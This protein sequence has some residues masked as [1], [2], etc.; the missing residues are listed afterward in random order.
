MIPDI[1]TRQNEKLQQDSRVIHMA[2]KDIMDKIRMRIMQMKIPDYEDLSSKQI[3][4]MLSHS[5]PQEIEDKI[6][7][8]IEHVQEDLEKAS[9]LS[10]ISFQPGAI[11]LETI[12]RLQ[13]EDEFCQQIKSEPTSYYTTRKGILLRIKSED[14]CKILMPK[15][16]LPECLI[17]MTIR[18]EHTKNMSVHLPFTRVVKTISSKY[19]FPK[20]YERI[21]NHVHKCIPC[22]LMSYHTRPPHKLSLFSQGTE[23]RQLIGLDL[24]VELPPVNSFKHVLVCVDYATNYVQAYPI[25]SRKSQD[26]LSAFTLF[27]QA[28]GIPHSVRH[29]QELGFTGAQFAQY[30]SDNNIEQLETLPYKANSNGKVEVQVRNF[31]HMLQKT[32]L[33]SDT[34]HQWP[35]EVWKVTV[36]LNT[37]VSMAYD[38]TPEEL[39][40]KNIL[41]NKQT[42]IATIT[43]TEHNQ[44]NLTTSTEYQKRKQQQQ[45]DYANKRRRTNTFEIGDL[46]LRKIICKAADGTKHAL[47]TKYNG[48]YRIM[49]K[50]DTTCIIKPVAENFHGTTVV[51]PDHLKPF[52][53]METPKL[54]P[55][56]NKAVARTLNM[57]NF[58]TMILLFMSLS[59]TL[60]SP[61]EITKIDII[62]ELDMKTQHMRKPILNDSWKNEPQSQ[63]NSKRGTNQPPTPEI[64][65]M[66]NPAR[67]EVHREDYRYDSDLI[68]KGGL[69]FKETNLILKIIDSQTSLT[70]PIDLD[71]LVKDA[72][73]W[74][75]IVTKANETLTLLE[76]NAT[77]ILEKKSK[78]FTP[79]TKEY[80]AIMWEH[81]LNNQRQQ[82]ELINNQYVSEVTD[83]LETY[84]KVI[85]EE[86]TLTPYRP[87]QARFVRLLLP[88]IKSLKSALTMAKPLSLLSKVGSAATI[89]HA[90]YSIVQ[91]INPDTTDEFMKTIITKVGPKIIKPIAE[92]VYGHTVDLNTEWQ[93]RFKSLRRFFPHTDPTGD[94]HFEHMPM[95]FNMLKQVHEQQDE[96]LNFHDAMKTTQGYVLNVVNK[97]L[98]K[99]ADKIKASKNLLE[100]LE[101]GKNIMQ[102][103]IL[104]HAWNSMMDQ[105]PDIK[106]H[107]ERGL[108]TIVPKLIHKKNRV[109]MEYQVDQMDPG[110]YK[111]YVSQMVSFETTQ[112]NWI[113][114]LPSIMMLK[115]H[116]NL[117]HIY[118]TDLQQC[119]KKQNKYICPKEILNRPQDNICFQA[120]LANSIE[121]I[122]SACDLK[123]SQNMN[124]L[125]Q[126]E[127]G[128]LYYDLPKN[129]IVTRECATLTELKLEGNGIITLP[130]H[131]TL[132]YK[133]KTFVNNLSTGNI[134]QQ[135]LEIARETLTHPEYIDSLWNR[136]KDTIGIA[137]LVTLLAVTISCMISQFS[138]ILTYLGLWKFQQTQKTQNDTTQLT[139]NSHLSSTNLSTM[140]R[141]PTPLR[142]CMTDPDAHLFNH[143]RDPGI[144]TYMNAD[145][146][147]QIAPTSLAGIK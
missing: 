79:A 105:Y 147:I 106:M 97:H 53:I 61:I 1:L 30:C 33:D 66:R 113:S 54:S 19:F 12:I 37:S 146:Q 94:I 47:D 131:C 63:N 81:D 137:S 111:M 138:N 11:P 85:P 40:F 135:V 43:I 10:A 22:Q 139:N 42:D 143:M 127:E 4:Q 17:E 16:V 31:K 55:H 65:S 134:R 27:V 122:Q 145:Q 109:L 50:T 90:G 62:H 26:I 129:A 121:A 91:S 102:S 44:D 9:I 136:H 112:S 38:R 48:P 6:S 104:K 51:H 56:W 101:N 74:N 80:K 84:N 60:G 52:N 64:L 88:M 13:N 86:K 100:D 99:R 76:S 20:L 28:F 125:I 57:N 103:S 95:I 92:K 110:T 96:F 41:Q 123:K 72:R 144:N 87:R 141:P 32:C 115:S 2:K 133:L 67:L 128:S 89:G 82:L 23:A 117:F 45:L 119:E 58:I 3:T 29:D 5:S 70:Q 108:E 118:A 59:L 126:L 7:N 124:S 73:E 83:L 140:A 14:G 142:P 25:K 78:M 71:H 120:H 114:Q 8:L 24:A 130:N 98:A 69:I 49:D 77:E 21:R 39:M 46:V 75:M 93:K 116:N 68:H 35:N 107:I 34:K 132:T 36:A 15:L 18:L